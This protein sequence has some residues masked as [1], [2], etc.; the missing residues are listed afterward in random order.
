MFKS[1]GS[2]SSPKLTENLS[3]IYTVLQKCALI[4]LKQ[5]VLRSTTVDIITR[6]LDNTAFVCVHVV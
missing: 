3:G 1:M 4:G 2:S 6:L 5:N